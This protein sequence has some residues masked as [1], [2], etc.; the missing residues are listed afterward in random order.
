MERVV[1]RDQQIEDMLSYLRSVGCWCCLVDTK[2][3]Q[4]EIIGCYKGR[5]VSFK[6][7]QKKPTSLE[8]A[9]L[10]SIQSVGGVAVVVQKIADIQQIITELEGEAC[11]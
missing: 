7:R 4:P 10:K 11:V 1:K 3:G 5:F 2:V 9:I 8:T 6:I